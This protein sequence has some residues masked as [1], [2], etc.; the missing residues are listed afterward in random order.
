MEKWRV[1]P[2]GEK[3]DQGMY[4]ED[5]TLKTFAQLQFNPSGSGVGVALAQS[6]DKGLSIL[7]C[8]PRTVAEVERVRDSEQAV[9]QSAATLTYEQ[10]KKLKPGLMCHPPN[11]TY[12]DLELL[13]STFCA[14]LWALF[15]DDCHYYQELM[16]LRGILNARDVSAIRDAFKV[17]ICRRIIWAIID[18]GRSF[19]RQKLTVEQFSD[20]RGVKFP[21]SLLSSIRKEVR[22][23]QVI[24]RPFY[25]TSWET[26]GTKADNGSSGGNSGG[27]VAT[28]G[29]IVPVGKGTW[30]EGGQEPQ[31]GQCR[32]LGHWLTRLGIR[33]APGREKEDGQTNST[34]SL[35]R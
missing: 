7:I 14:L 23:A 18:D 11:G 22:F 19:F 20:P 15:G 21:V 1:K 32:K 29:Q 27:G 35:R 5:D 12:L 17:D 16:G 31:G 28:E 8:R 6:A 2:V 26:Q 4:L 25:P 9:T 24:E 33:E 3:I 30:V 13:V 34:H 10:A